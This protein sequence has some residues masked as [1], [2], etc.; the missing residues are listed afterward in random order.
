MSQLAGD[1]VKILQV[2]IKENRAFLY[3]AVRKITS[4]ETEF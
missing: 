3:L 4:G 1:A 2:E